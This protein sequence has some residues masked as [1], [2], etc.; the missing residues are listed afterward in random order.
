ML[1]SIIA[2]IGCIENGFVIAVLIRAKQTRTSINMTIGSLALADILQCVIYCTFGIGRLY[3]PKYVMGSYGC[4]N[5]HFFKIASDAVH[6]LSIIGMVSGRICSLFMSGNSPLLSSI[7]FTILLLICMWSLC[8]AGAFAA[9]R[10]IWTSSLCQV[11][12]DAGV[13]QYRCQEADQGG[14]IFWIICVSLLVDVPL[15]L[16]LFMYGMVWYMSRKYAAVMRASI[17]ES[18]GSHA[19]GMKPAN[20]RI[21]LLYALVAVIFQI[22]DQVYVLRRAGDDVHQ[23]HEVDTL[24]QRAYLIL[25]YFNCLNSC[26]NPLIFAF[27]S[28]TF[29][30][31]LFSMIRPGSVSSRT[32]NFDQLAE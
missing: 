7:R 29:R 15:L 9:S 2:A 13:V 23:D 14:L 24:T 26:V 25:H 32:G 20:N 6:Q 17:Q 19:G 11:V 4:R 30:K 21:L 22:P 27:A 31:A 16:L 8:W 28:K 1:L 12:T 5:E 10:R 18:S 3:G